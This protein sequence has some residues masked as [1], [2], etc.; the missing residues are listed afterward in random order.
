MRSIDPKELVKKNPAIDAQRFEEARAYRRSLPEPL[1]SGPG[2]HLV[3]P[4]GG[5]RIRVAE[6]Q[7]ADTKTV[8]V[9]QTLRPSLR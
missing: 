5:Q 2:Y 4:Y 3:P 1:H 9:S 7:R 6:D 8:A